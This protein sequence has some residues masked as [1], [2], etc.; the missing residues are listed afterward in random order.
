MTDGQHTQ[1]DCKSSHDLW[2]GE[3]KSLKKI[4]NDQSNT[5]Q[6]CSHIIPD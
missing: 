5:Y 6:N 2:S 3:L 1:T 4:I